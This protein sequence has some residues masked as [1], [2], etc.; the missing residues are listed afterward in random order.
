MNKLILLFLLCV[1]SFVWANESSGTTAAREWLQ[2]VDAGDYAE[3]WQKS[4]S[5]FKS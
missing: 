4:D 5:F 2:T 3:S 1:S